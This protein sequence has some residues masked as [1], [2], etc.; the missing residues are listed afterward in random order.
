[1][2]ENRSSTSAVSLSG[3]RPRPCPMR[4]EADESFV[5]AAGGG[6]AEEGQVYVRR[7]VA[8]AGP[9]TV[10]PWLR[11]SSWRPRAAPGGNCRR[12]SGPRL[13]H[14]LPPVFPV[15]PGPGLGQ[16]VPRDP[17]RTRSARRAGLVAVCDR[18]RQP[19]GRKGG[20]LTG[21]NPTYRGK[22]GSKIHLITDR[23]GL[24]LLL[25]ISGANMHDSQGL[26][27]LCAASR[28][29]GPA[30][31]PGAG[32]RRNCT[33][34]R[35]TT[36]TTCAD[37]SAGGESV[38]ASPARASSPHSGWAPASVGGRENRVLAGRLPKAPPPLRTQGRTPPCLR[39][40]SRDPH[41]LPP[42]GCPAYGLS[43]FSCTSKQTNPMDSATAA[44]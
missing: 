40:H 14:G 23:S 32:G 11:S 4:L 22:L 10:K 15:E 44:A 9:E 42:T 27:R 7:A 16:A 2:V 6:E 31:G 43:R 21:P 34:T 5:A 13:A 17:R 19:A 3:S 28:P 12:C 20:P 1:M 39:R 38:T 29:S 25:G 36:T 30:A 18:L 26:S 41:R 35:A 24:P 37:G 8:G 33:R